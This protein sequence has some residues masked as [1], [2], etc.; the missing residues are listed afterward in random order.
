MLSNIAVRKAFHVEPWMLYV[1]SMLMALTWG[2]GN[3][4]EIKYLKETGENI[5][6]LDDLSS[7][8]GTPMK[9]VDGEGTNDDE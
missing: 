8:N 7:T 6:K 5:F 4:E 3:L 1:N 9:L 2:G